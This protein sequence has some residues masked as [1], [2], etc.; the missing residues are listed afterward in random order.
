M[1]ILR[2]MCDIKEYSKLEKTPYQPQIDDKKKTPELVVDDKKNETNADKERLMNKMKLIE[3]C[4]KICFFIGIVAIIVL[5]VPFYVTWKKVYQRDYLA[6]TN[7]PV[8]ITNHTIKIDLCGN[9]ACYEGIYTGRYYSNNQYIYFDS[10]VLHQ[11]ERQNVVD[12]L[13]Y[14]YPIGRIM[15]MWCKNNGECGF[16]ID[17][18]ENLWNSWIALFV[19]GGYFFVIGIVGRIYYAFLDVKFRE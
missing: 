12:W 5:G 4:I 16:N 9:D 11:R 19:I 17:K 13:D 6:Y 10:I 14:E 2:K 15:D 18:H 3:E 1:Y 8:T 7:V